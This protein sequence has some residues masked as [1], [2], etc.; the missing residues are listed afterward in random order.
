MWIGRFRPAA[1]SQWEKC[2]LVC[3]NLTE[4]Q[5]MTDSNGDGN[6]EK[7][8]ER[9]R[10]RIIETGMDGDSEQVTDDRV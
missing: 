9:K 8:K 7:P 6:A 3:D 2:L 10:Q 4:K 5:R 1:I